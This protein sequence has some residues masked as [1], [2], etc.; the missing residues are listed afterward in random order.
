MRNFVALLLS[1]QVLAR[2][3]YSSSPDVYLNGLQTN[4]TSYVTTIDPE[5]EWG[6]WEGFKD[7]ADCGFANMELRTSAQKAALGCRPPFP[8]PGG[9]PCWEGWPTFCAQFSMP[10][11][12]TAVLRILEGWGVSLCWWA[13]VLGQRDDVADLIFSKKTVRIAGF[14]LPGLALNIARY[15][16]GASSCWKK[17]LHLSRR[18]LN[19]KKLDRTKT[20]SFFHRG[21]GASSWN[22]YYGISMKTSPNIPEFKQ[23]QGFWQDWGSD[24]PTSSSWNWSKC[25]QSTSGP[26]PRIF[27]EMP[28]IKGLKVK[29]LTEDIPCPCQR[30]CLFSALSVVHS[31]C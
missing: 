16:A 27:R 9:G 13:K 25:Q 24:D 31:S 4:R 22:S 5:T 11:C 7:S 26:T 29:P 12:Q 17:E 6:K 3:K 23:I 14:K 21:A 8:G 15:N 1:H 18:K 2:P 28:F 30:G 20:S 10:H 19:S